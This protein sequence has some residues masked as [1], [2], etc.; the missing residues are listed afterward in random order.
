MTYTDHK[1][2]RYNRTREY[3]W[4]PLPVRRTPTAA[5][6]LATISYIPGLGLLA[7]PAVILAAASNAHWEHPVTRL[8]A[9]RALKVAAVSLLL[10]ALLVVAVLVLGVNLDTWRNL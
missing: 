7:I 4:A 9:D 5:L 6:T 3:G 1:T 10:N 2:E 8:R